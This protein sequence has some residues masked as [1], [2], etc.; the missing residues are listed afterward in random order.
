[1]LRSWWWCCVALAG[2]GLG[3]HSHSL[4]LLGLTHGA[5]ASRFGATP[6]GLLSTLVCFL[7]I[8]LAVYYL[9]RLQ[10]PRS[11]SCPSPATNRYVLLYETFEV[12]EAM[13]R[14]IW[15]AVYSTR[16]FIKNIVRRA[17]IINKKSWDFFMDNLCG[18]C[19]EPS[20]HMG[21]RLVY[22]RLTFINVV[23]C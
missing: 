22:I 15:F 9:C 4:T 21:N 16:A 12:G 6:A 13:D 17:E 5:G 20:Q 8:Y 10:M 14:G 1:M 3:R 2:P 18:Y 11:S 7:P 23:Q 19:C